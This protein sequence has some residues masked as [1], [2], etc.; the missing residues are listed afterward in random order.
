MFKHKLKKNVL[1]G[2]A[3]LFGISSDKVTKK[4]TETNLRHAPLSL[5]LIKNRLNTDFFG[6]VIEYSHTVDST[7][8]K[9]KKHSKLPSGTL[10]LADMQTSG[11][12]RLGREWVSDPNSGIYMSLLLTPP[13]DVEKIPQVTLIAGIA[14]CRALECNAKIKW[15]NDIIIGSKKLC[16][17]L[18]E[19]LTSANSTSCIICGIGINVNNTCIPDDLSEK[20][21]SFFIETGKFR[22]RETLIA[23]ILNE[24]EPMYTKFLK[25]GFAPFLTEYRTLCD[26]LGKE[27]NAVYKSNTVTAVAEDI[28]KDG[29]L[30]I[31]KGDE[32]ISLSSGEVS[33]RGIYGYV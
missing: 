5:D 6:A 24:F 21:T 4:E 2:I 11:K 3:A 22:S 26:T 7:N 29:S 15:P 33:V 8:E 28:A 9:A 23:D 25:D 17:I 32:T 10:F 20:A 16:G 13:D 14:V 27:I 31:K 19:G 30:I 18:T 1:Q 12:G